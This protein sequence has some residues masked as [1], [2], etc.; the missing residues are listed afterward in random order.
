MLPTLTAGQANA[1]YTDYIG[2]SHAAGVVASASSTD[3]GAVAQNTVNGS[4]LT[5]NSHS[6]EWSH[7]WTSNGDSGNPPATSPTP[8]S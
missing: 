5:G 7:T 4:G 2:A 6:T 1:T 8:G 3:P